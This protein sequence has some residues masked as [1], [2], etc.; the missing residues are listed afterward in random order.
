[1]ALARVRGFE[2]GWRMISPANA[3]SLRTVE[4]TG[5]GGIRVVKE[6]RYVKVLSK[7]HSWSS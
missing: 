3:A 6:L 1:M 2:E 4:K 5:G 7:V